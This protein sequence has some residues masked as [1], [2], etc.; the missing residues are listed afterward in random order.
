MG[1]LEYCLLA[2]SSLFVVVDPVTLIPVFLAMTPR[3][4]PADRTRMARTASIV[5]AGILL[6]FALFGVWVFRLLG[7]SVTAFQLAGSVLLLLIAL[8]ML[9]GKPST[10]RQSEEE[11]DEGVEKKDIAVTPLG[12]PLLAGPGAI[13]TVLMLH[14]QAT[15]IPR[16]I[17]L[18]GSIVV[19]CAA[20]Y[21][22]LRLAANGMHWIRPIA[23]KIATRLMGLL[24]AAIAMQFL[25][26]AVKTT[27]SLPK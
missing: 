26:D 3:D 6:G 25:I 21:V 12:I 10:V 17:A 19:V 24:L 18:S 2:L 16:Y 8:E 22:C 20:S 4:S 5:A 15:D 1:F 9:R 7:I 11:T 23:M 13:T 27:L 14:D